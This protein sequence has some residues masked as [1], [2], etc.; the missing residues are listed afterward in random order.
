MS[1]ISFVYKK[2]NVQNLYQNKSTQPWTTIYSLTPFITL[3]SL[4]LIS[5]Q[6]KI[7]AS[8]GWKIQLFF[9]C[10]F[11]V[12]KYFLKCFCVCLSQNIK[13]IQTS[14]CKPENHTNFDFLKQ[15]QWPTFNHDNVD[16]TNK[17]WVK[18]HIYVATLIIVEFSQEPFWL[19][20]FLKM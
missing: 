3:K 12:S 20:L 17:I 5:K 16:I 8:E 6:M 1:V 9:F 18:N 7:Y 4:K 19:P 14:G 11:F 2:S 13:H 10:F 15:I